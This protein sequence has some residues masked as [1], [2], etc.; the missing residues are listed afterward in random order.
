MLTLTGYRSFDIALAFLGGDFVNFDHDQAVDT[1]IKIRI[2]IKVDKV[3]AFV[4][5]QLN[6]LLVKRRHLNARSFL[7]SLFKTLKL[8]E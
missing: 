7:S 6:I 3:T 2:N 8:M 5:A 1:I 4:D